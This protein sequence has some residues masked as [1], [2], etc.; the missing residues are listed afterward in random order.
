MAIFSVMHYF[1]F[2]WKEY[3]TSRYKSDPLA[4]PGVGYSGPGPT[5]QGGRFG[6]KAYVDSF[7]PWDIL[8]AT[9][10]GFRWLFVGRKRRFQDPSYNTVLGKANIVSGSTAPP[11]Y[12]GPVYTGGQGPATELN[13]NRGRTDTTTTDSD[14]A[15]LLANTH[16]TSPGG[17]EGS[18]RYYRASTGEEG[19]LSLQHNQSGARPPMSSEYGG[20]E[21][22]GMHPGYAQHMSSQM[23]GSSEDTGYHA[24]AAAPSE[25]RQQQ[26][27]QAGMGNAG[28]TG[29]WDMWAGARRD[30]DEWRDASR[31]A[32]RSD[33]GY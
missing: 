26:P 27:G 19:D 2:P 8:K 18:R 30:T 29:E 5:Y 21:D 7:N 32:G 10:R 15:G 17:P 4:A 13:S 6:M 1:A 12:E 14:T 31:G 28:Q 23:S 20:R 24:P 33:R 22:T 11:S 9:A 16:H 3:N 25:H